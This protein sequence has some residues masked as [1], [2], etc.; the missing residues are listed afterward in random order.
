[1]LPFRGNW[2]IF[3]SGSWQLDQDASCFIT[4]LYYPS[5]RVKEDASFGFFGDLLIFV[6]V[7]DVGVIWQLGELKIPPLE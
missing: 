5:A 4:H 3:L 7:H 2:F 6:E 1:M